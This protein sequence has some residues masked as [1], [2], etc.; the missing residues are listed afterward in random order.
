MILISLYTKAT[1]TVIRQTDGNRAFHLRRIGA[2][3][4]STQEVGEIFLRAW[5]A[6]KPTFE[7]TVILAD[8]AEAHPN[9]ARM[10]LPFFCG[11]GF[12]GRQAQRNISPTS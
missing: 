8:A 5:R 12:S 1:R 10:V 7:P 3:T 4:N 9:A 11:S 6:Q 2:A